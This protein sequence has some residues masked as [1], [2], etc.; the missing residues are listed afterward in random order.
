LNPATYFNPIPSRLRNIDLAIAK[1]CCVRVASPTGEAQI[2]FAGSYTIS[3]LVRY[4]FISSIP[5]IKGKQEKYLQEVFSEF[6]SL[7][8]VGKMPE[9]LAK[10][11]S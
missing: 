11:F 6:V 7:S 2:A 9:L 1:R 4:T 10:A 8:A 5:C 3:L